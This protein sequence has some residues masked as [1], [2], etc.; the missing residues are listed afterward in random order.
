MALLV[1]LFLNLWKSL[2]VSQHCLFLSSVSF[3]LF[4]YSCVKPSLE[5]VWWMSGSWIII[6]GGRWL[7]TTMCVFLCSVIKY[8]IHGIHGTARRMIYGVLNAQRAKG[9]SPFHTA[10]Y[11]WPSGLG[12]LYLSVYVFLHLYV[13]VSFLCQRQMSFPW[14][15]TLHC[16][17]EHYFTSIGIQMIIRKWQ[18]QYNITIQQR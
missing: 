6:K 2:L 4:F 17:S 7:I 16:K 11:P 14:K 3:P 10:L 5:V 9:W 13:S 8:I 1:P 15:V 18:K 12:F